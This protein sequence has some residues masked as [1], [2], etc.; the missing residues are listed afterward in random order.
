MGI[1]FKNLKEE[2]NDEKIKRYL[3]FGFVGM[4]IVYAI[5][6]ILM[7]LSKTP[8]DKM[9]SGQLSFSRDYIVSEIYLET[10]DLDL[11]RYAQI[12]DY[13]FMLTYSTFLF[14]L[15]V[16]NARKLKQKSSLASL[17]YKMAEFAIVA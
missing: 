1:F 4:V 13:G 7:Y 3:I 12:L 17:G 11:Y 16:R 2:P 6:G 14:S 8:L 10:I 15:S 5:M 9:I